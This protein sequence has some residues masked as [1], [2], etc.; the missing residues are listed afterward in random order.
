MHCYFSDEDTVQ[1]NVDSM[2]TSSSQ[3]LS[4]LKRFNPPV[5]A[6]GLKNIPRFI[7]PVSLHSSL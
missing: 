7:I 1:S 2:A 3:I 4:R 5:W 6:Q